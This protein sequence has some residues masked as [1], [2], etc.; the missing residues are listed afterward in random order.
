MLRF[1]GAPDAS[2]IQTALAPLGVQDLLELVS[3]EG[4]AEIDVEA[5]PEAMPEPENVPETVPE[6]M[7]EAMPEA[8]EEVPEGLHVVLH[9]PLVALRQ[10]PSL[11]SPVV[12]YVRH[13]A[14]VRL[15]DWDS[16][17]QWRM[18]QGEQ[19]W[20]PLRHPTL[21]PLVRELGVKEPEMT[22]QEA[23]RQLY[24]AGVLNMP[25]PEGMNEAMAAS[26]AL[27]DAACGLPCS[28]EGEKALAHLDVE[29]VKYVMTAA[30][31]HL[32]RPK[33]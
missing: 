33:A 13:G 31:E 11:R 12:R 29:T 25:P 24:E 16:T 18:V 5:V 27:A 2:A 10:E 32:R 4:E 21:G 26:Q 14:H 7:P 6:A 28:A 1:L 23:W 30:L 17:Q 20:M 15:G 3:G 8:S 22:V 9:R 19:A